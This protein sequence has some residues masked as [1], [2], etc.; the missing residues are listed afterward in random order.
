M[1]GTMMGGLDRPAPGNIMFKDRWADLQRRFPDKPALQ[2]SNF[3][4]FPSVQ[5]VTPEWQ[6]Q[7]MQQYQQ[8]PKGWTPSG[9][10]RGGRVAFPVQSRK[11]DY[12]TYHPS[13]W[14][15]DWGAAA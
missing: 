2:M 1:P 10:Q 11:R 13:Q 9:L 7:M 5:K 3:M 4:D 14:Q 15:D 8:I 6:D 12:E